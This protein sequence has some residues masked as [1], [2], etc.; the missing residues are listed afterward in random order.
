[1][2]VAKRM[3]IGVSCINPAGTLQCPTC[4]KMGKESF[5]C[6]QDCFKNS[7]VRL[8]FPFSFCLPAEPDFPPS[9]P[10]KKPLRI[11]V[12]QIKPITKR[13]TCSLPRFSAFRLPLLNLQS[14]HKAL[15][16][17]STA[18][19]SSLLQSL[20]DFA[21]PVPLSANP[22]TGAFDPFPLFAY[23]GE[24]R[25]IYPLSPPRTVPS[26]IKRPDYAADGIP[27]SE[28]ALGSSSRKISIL[29]PPECQAMRK[30]CRLAREVLDIAAAAAKPGV[31]TDEIDA[32]VHDACV[33]R[34]VR[35][36]RSSFQSSTDGTSHTPRH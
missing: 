18:G 31:T 35:L 12:L 5:F 29:S 2:S 20:K 15:H 1:M 32:I 27:R 30:V 34:N 6:S 17:K 3:C 26:H 16:R 13:L 10:K 25:P 24:I 22:V 19:K 8:I 23:T 36:P 7:W 21:L 28:Y 4:L 11:G 9:S 33:E 14:E